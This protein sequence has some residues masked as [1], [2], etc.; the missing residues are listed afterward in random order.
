MCLGVER[1]FQRIGTHQRR[2]TIVA[3]FV[4][5]LI[6]DVDPSVFLVEFLS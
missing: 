4:A 1:L 5:H 2:G 3:V 6:G